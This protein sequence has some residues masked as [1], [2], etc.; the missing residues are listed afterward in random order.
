MVQLTESPTWIFVVVGKKP[1]KSRCAT[2]VGFGGPAVTGAMRPRADELAA[3][4]PSTRV[5]DAAA[6]DTLR[7]LRISIPAPPRSSN[8]RACYSI[9]RNPELVVGDI[10]F[11]PAR[12]A[13][14]IGSR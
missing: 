11:S 12:N 7:K 2:C 8:S 13:A 3:V 9:A 10:R 4:K 5:A 6:V 14:L 1:L